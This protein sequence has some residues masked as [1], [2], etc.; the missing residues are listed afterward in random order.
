MCDEQPSD[1]SLCD[2]IAN[3][4]FNSGS[5]SSECESPS[6]ET[7]Q[8]KPKRKYNKRA[9]AK[10]SELNRVGYNSGGTVQEPTGG[11][12]VQQAR[13]KRERSRKHKQEL[14][15]Q[16]G[17]VTDGFTNAKSVPRA[18]KPKRKPVRKVDR[19]KE[20][21]L[22]IEED[23]E[24]YEKEIELDEIIREMLPMLRPRPVPPMQSVLNKVTSAFMGCPVLTHVSES[25]PGNTKLVIEIEI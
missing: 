25:K 13:K 5:N 20:T 6:M 11:S 4:E 9:K 22:E 2:S 23:M 10:D 21:E 1:N 19:R 16:F 15:A 18:G 3:M 8:T 14:A 17:L 24:P 7:E 12:T